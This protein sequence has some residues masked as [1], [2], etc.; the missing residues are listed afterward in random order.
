MKNKK[1]LCNTIIT[2]SQA[3]N[4]C[5]RKYLLFNCLIDLIYTVDLLYYNCVLSVYNIVIR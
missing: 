1:I 2:R 3:K 5:D 4:I